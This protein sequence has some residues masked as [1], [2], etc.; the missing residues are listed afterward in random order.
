MI[1]KTVV[2]TLYL[3]QSRT[4]DQSEC[5]NFC[6]SKANCL[7]ENNLRSTRDSYLQIILR[8]HKNKKA[9]NSQLQSQ[10]DEYSDLR[11]SRE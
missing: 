4:H 1:S 8:F 2:F 7:A 6:H 3:L 11:T 9:V 10:V 5:T